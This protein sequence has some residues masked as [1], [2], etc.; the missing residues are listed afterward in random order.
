[1]YIIYILHVY[2]YVCNIYVLYVYIYMYI[3]Y[4]LFLYI[5]I[6][7]SRKITQF[8][9]FYVTLYIY[10]VFTAERFEHTSTGFC[11]DA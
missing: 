1:M 11:S 8:P 9:Q 4:I 2:I 10:V 7:K 3:L 6:H 5:Y